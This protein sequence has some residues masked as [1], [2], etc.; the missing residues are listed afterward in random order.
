[1]DVLAILLGSVGVGGLVA[2]VQWRR[3]TWLDVADVIGRQTSPAF[4]VSIPVL[5]VVLIAAALAV[6]WTWGLWV[7]IVSVLAW[8]AVLGS[9]P[10]AQRP[11][12]KPSE[13]I[14]DE[15][16]SPAVRSDADERESERRAS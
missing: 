9:D 12:P 8:L 16:P 3:G 5:G 10:T 14:R 7:L 13:L 2:W 11:A 6:L 15:P 1:M 4:V